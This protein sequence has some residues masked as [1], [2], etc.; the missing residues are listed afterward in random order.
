VQTA[1]SHLMQAQAALKRHRVIA[2]VACAI[3]V[4][5]YTFFIL[6]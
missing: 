5:A 1:R 2:Y 6:R 4:V 3:A